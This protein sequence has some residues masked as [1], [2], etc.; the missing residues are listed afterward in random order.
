MLGHLQGQVL[1]LQFT[2]DH[3][4]HIPA[5]LRPGGKDRVLQKLLGD[6]AGSLLLLAQGDEEFPP[7]P[8]HALDVNAVVLIKPFVLNGH[9]RMGKI[10]RNQIHAVDLDSVGIGGHI[11]VNLIALAV[12]DNA[13]LPHRHHIAQADIGSCG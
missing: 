2:L 12:V 8:G 7:G 11:L 3:F 13:G 9:K 5:L 4:D 10:L 6:G 1:L